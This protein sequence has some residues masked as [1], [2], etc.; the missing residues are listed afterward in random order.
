M[1]ATR[2]SLQR[3]F[4][5]ERDE[6]LSA[7]VRIVKVDGR[8]K[9]RPSLLC[10]TCWLLVF[11]FFFFTLKAKMRKLVLIIRI[12]R[13]KAIQT[14]FSFNLLLNWFSLII[15][16]R[17]LKSKA[18]QENQKR[19]SEFKCFSGFLMREVSKKHELSKSKEFEARQFATIFS[20]REFLS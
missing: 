9:K 12:Y 17:R 15:L 7:F 5:Q 6:R 16:L 14:E 13:Y 11:C 10:I 4:F 19:K 1:N 3:Q 8:K 20:K 2:A 18:Q